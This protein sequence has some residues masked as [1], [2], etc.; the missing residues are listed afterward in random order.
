M[1]VGWKCYI[2]LCRDFIIFCTVLDVRANVHFF[3]FWKLNNFIWQ[4]DFV[5]N[6][7]AINLIVMDLLHWDLIGLFFKKNDDNSLSRSLSFSF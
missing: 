2:F 7:V 5:Q 4:F 6:G 3:A 1:E